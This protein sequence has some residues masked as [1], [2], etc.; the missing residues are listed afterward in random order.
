MADFDAFGQCVAAVYGEE[1]EWEKAMALLTEAQAGFALEDEPLYPVLKELLQAGDLQEQKTSDFYKLVTDT[2]AQL[3][4]GK[5]IP[6]SAEAC[7]ARV[8][9]LHTILE[10]VL[11]LTIT[12]RTLHGYRFIQITR[13]PNCQGLGVTL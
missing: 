13:G 3:R 10:S 11:D 6:Q 12:L 9:Q 7:T 4:L 1:R 5:K 2:A 8:H